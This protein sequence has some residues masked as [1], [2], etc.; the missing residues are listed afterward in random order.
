MPFTAADF[1]RAT[2]RPPTDD[3]LERA[4]CSKAG[5]IGHMN[6]G[7]CYTSNLPKFQCHWCFTSQ[8]HE[9]H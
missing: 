6:C 5:E 9:D 2:G 1:D 4:N 7:W 8:P 3:D